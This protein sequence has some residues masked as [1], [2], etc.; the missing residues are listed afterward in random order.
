MSIES[1]FWV[2]PPAEPDTYQLITA[3][4]AGGE[5]QVWKAVVPLSDAGRRQVAI[6]ILPQAAWINEQEWA[7]FGHLLKSLS[8]PGLVRVSDVFTGP[9]MHRHQQI[10]PGQYRYVVMEFI[11]GIT[12]AE[13]LAENPDI[14]VTARIAA[15]R[16][17]AA[18]LDEMHS[19]RT[20]EVPVAHGDVKPTNIILK[21]D[22][23]TVLVDLGLARLSDSTGVAGRTNPYAAPELHHEAA[24]VTPESDRFAFVATLAHL[25]IGEP[26]PIDQRGQI[27]LP[28]LEQRLMTNPLTYR[29]PAL[30]R[31]VLTALA[32]PPDA[33]PRH[34]TEWLA[35]TSG[36][37][38]QVTSGVPPQQLYATAPPPPIA[39]HNAVPTPTQPTPPTQPRKR[40]WLPALI[41]AAAVLAAGAG[42][43]TGWWLHGTSSAAVAGT[44]TTT[45][46]RTVVETTTAAATPAKIITPDPTPSSEASSTTPSTTAAQVTR[47]GEL[48]LNLG[49]CA[50]LNSTRPDWQVTNQCGT[51]GAIGGDA[52][53]RYIY[54]AEGLYFVNG[55]D[56]AIV[57]LPDSPDTAEAFTTC[58]ST[59][60]YTE[61]IPVNKIVPG[62]ALCVRTASASDPDNADQKHALLI[63]KSTDASPTDPYNFQQ[64]AF[65]VKV[66]D[67]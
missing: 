49:Y 41:A 9:A 16:T 21:P 37:V 51:Y 8:H 59:S 15:L 27:N 44:T 31:A 33:R 62:L 64:V 11:E 50:D 14:T 45:E 5:G 3:L 29:R 61:T 60:N 52:D 36:T 30:I 56:A 32:A 48:T 40:R 12:L 35:A 13:W 7:R 63:V 20:T 24:Q 54:T 26:P 38:S 1:S 47:Q 66:Y 65:D 53:L 39:G 10:P 22:G 55:A 57:S 28:A 18:A 42:L 34:L 2:G 43:V 23:G 19:G 67:R 6:K 4:G 58:E 25:L 46:T 17:V